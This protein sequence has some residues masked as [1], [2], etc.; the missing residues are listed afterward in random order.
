[1]KEKNYWNFRRG[2]HKLRIETSRFDQIPKANKLYPICKS[3]RNEFESHFLM[4]CIKYSIQMDEFYWKIENIVSHF[5]QFS[6]LQPTGK[7][8][9]ATN[10]Y[11]VSK[12]T[13]PCFDLRN[14]LLSNRTDVTLLYIHDNHCYFSL[15]KLLR[16]WKYLW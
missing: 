7:I 15:Q 14:M 1:M 2:N 12:F 10:Q 9:N 3:N 4:C 11:S 16:H 6:P 13:S 8:M 5:T